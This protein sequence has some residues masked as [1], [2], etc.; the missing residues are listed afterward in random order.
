MH[1]R[2]QPSDQ[3]TTV[4]TCR[5]YRNI[6][7]LHTAYSACSIVI[8]SGQNKRVSGTKVVAVQNVITIA[9]NFLIPSN[10]TQNFGTLTPLFWGEQLIQCFFAPPHLCAKNE[11]DPC[12][13]L[14]TMY[15]VARIPNF[16]LILIKAWSAS[17]ALCKGQ[18]SWVWSR[19]AHE[20]N[21][22]ALATGPSCTDCLRHW[23]RLTVES[24]LSRS[25][26][27]NGVDDYF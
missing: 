4:T 9:W 19:D 17:S 21:C 26:S 2:Y 1:A 15:A 11:S 10:W 23:R 3:P 7:H 8:T 22:R 20:H 27:K 25:C 24:I 13:G 6:R 16:D 12:S 14:A 18:K 5:N